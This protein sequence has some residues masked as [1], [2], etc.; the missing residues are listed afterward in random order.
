[1]RVCVFT[2]S[3]FLA[4]FVR[5]IKERSSKMYEVVLGIVFNMAAWNIEFAFVLQ[6]SWERKEVER[7]EM[8]L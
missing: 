5:Y 1:M 3:C 6:V 7:D 2:L 4:K 8:E